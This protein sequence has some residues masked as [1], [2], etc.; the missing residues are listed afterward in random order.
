M[1]VKLCD[2]SK[3]YREKILFKNISTE[4]NVNQ[5]YGIAGHNGSG[6]STLLKIIMGYVTP[7]S[8]NISYTLEQKELK[9]EHLYTEISF[10]APYLDIPSDL[11]LY[12]LFDFHFGMRKRRNGL[13][14]DTINQIFDLPTGLPI[15]QFSSGMQQRVKLSLAF[16]TQS[17]LLILDEPTETLDQK[18][19]E[20]YK[21]LLENYTENR[22]VLIASNKTSD[23]IGCSSI[24]D[25]SLSI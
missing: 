7:T 6:K 19:F 10:A 4:F 25:I 5:R 22:T 12:E 3:S 8:G 9:A 11:N 21:F 1:N 16:F 2:I 18:G 20:Q 15:K 24:M 13:S 17:S 23:F 14:N